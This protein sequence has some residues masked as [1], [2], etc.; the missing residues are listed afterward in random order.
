MVAQRLLRGK[1]MEKE[2]STPICGACIAVKGTKQ[3][4]LS[5]RTGG[6]ELT[7]PTAGAYTIEVSAVGYKR[8]REVV[9]AGGDV[10]RDYYLEPSSTSLREVVV[11]SSAQS[12]EIN[13]IR[14]SPM[15]VTVVDGAKLRGR[16]S[17]IE[18]ILTR[19]S[20]IK[21][22]RAGGLGS[23]SRISVHGLEGK[24]VAVY[25]DGFPLNSPDGRSILTTSR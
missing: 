18:E 23:A 11:R 12:A 16:S 20:G 9:V 6:Y 22:R 17:S 14:Q 24:R 4:V 1:I 8:L 7:V 13:Q 25:I 10:T 15:A 2:T 3:K 5:D 21:V 19:T